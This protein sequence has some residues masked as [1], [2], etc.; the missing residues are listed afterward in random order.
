[1]LLI[2]GTVPIKNL[3]LTIGEARVVGDLL[4]VKDYNISCIQGTASMINAAVK[5]TEYF[6]INKPQVLI[7]GDIGDGN[8]SREIYKYLIKNLKVISPSILT[9]HYCMPYIIMITKLCEVINELNKR[10]IMIADAGSMYAAKA[11][12][13][14]VNF[15]V[16]TPDAT[17][18]AFLADSNAT[19]PA[20]IAKHFFDNDINQTPKL[21]KIAYKN[22]D[23]AKLLLVKGSTDYIALDGNIIDVVNK[24]DIPAM[25]AI[26]GTGDTITGLI[27]ALIYLGLDLKK[28]ALVAARSNRI[29][30][31]YAK[32]NPATKISQIIAQFSSAFQKL[33]L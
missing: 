20:Y 33:K 31:E 32:A 15:D 5:T 18:M 8:G 9:L 27:S 22:K 16:F 12:G 1:M 28:A 4:V 6:N 3:P 17:E 24:P 30:G 14:A 23:I 26:G 2:V 29:A 25:E 13:M 11:S 10:P 19:H 7:A 21:V